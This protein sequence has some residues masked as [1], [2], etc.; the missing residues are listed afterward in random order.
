MPQR[1]QQYPGPEYRTLPWRRRPMAMPQCAAGDAW[2]APVPRDGSEKE[3]LPG[4]KKQHWPSGAMRC[5]L[6]DSYFRGW[7]GRVRTKPV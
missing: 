6:C 5:D 3:L 1:Q 2:A 7:R 4:D